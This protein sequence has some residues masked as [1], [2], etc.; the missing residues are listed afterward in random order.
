M[1]KR[2]ATLFFGWK[3]LIFFFS[4]LAVF[5]LRFNPTHGFSL[6]Y[7]NS[8]NY[9]LGIWANFDG[10][11]YL[12]IA[13]DG[14][15][16]PNFAYFPLLPFLVSILHK[17][18]S[19][20]FLTS[21]LLITNF[22]FF[23]SLF[24]FYKLVLLDF[25]QKI[26]WRSF[27]FL[28][29]F[30][31]SFF[32][33]AVYTESLYFLFATLSFYC[34]RKSRWPLAGIFGL[35]AGLARLVGL[36]LIV[37]LLVEWYWQNK[38]KRDNLLENFLKRKVYFIFLIPL[39]M[40]LYGLYLQINFGDFFLFQKSMIHWGQ[41]N[42]ISPFQVLFRYLKIIIFASKNITYFTAILELG[43]TFFY[44]FLG[45]YVLK[46]V[47]VSYG[48]WMIVSLLIPT[49]TGTL[50]SMPRYILHLFPAFIALAL[51]SEKKNLYRILVFIFIL[52]QFLLVALFTRG[53]FIA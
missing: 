32:Y 19:F 27:F 46:K 24:V 14:Y 29:I 36:S 43:S 18:T 21:G 25:D 31:V 42:F 1:F 38:D 23:L 30:P 12:N 52:L 45:F 37:A 41:A 33:G 2:I 48:V 5:I 39:G 34:A 51:I 6:N 10:A 22:A 7:L 26:A 28:L 16:Y 9:F 4:L 15:H 50:Q 13:R 44:F 49:F 40:I 3:I 20:S 47:R 8:P 35:M 53:Y 17:L 11:N